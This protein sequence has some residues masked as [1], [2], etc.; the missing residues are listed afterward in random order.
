MGIL[1]TLLILRII[2]YRT[3]YDADV[4]ACRMAESLAGQFDQL[5][6]HYDDASATLSAALI[7]VTFDHPSAR[8]ATW[9]H[10]VSPIESLA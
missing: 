5:P 9:L 1:M 2:S 8:K 3:E 10:P 4:R 7:R 6:S